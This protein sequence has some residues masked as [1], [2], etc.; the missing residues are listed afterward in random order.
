MT[1][2]F[3]VLVIVL[4]LALLIWDLVV[5]FR[6]IKL[7]IKICRTTSLRRLFR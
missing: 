1:T 4:V 7:I 5:R 6:I 2:L 3:I